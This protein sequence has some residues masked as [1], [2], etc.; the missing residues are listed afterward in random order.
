MGNEKSSGREGISAEQAEELKMK[1]KRKRE[2]E[3]LTALIHLSRIC[4]AESIYMKL[5]FYRK[6]CLE[7][8]EGN[9]RQLERC[10]RMKMK[11][12]HVPSPCLCCVIS[13]SC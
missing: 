12:R 3:V 2:R 11:S 10:W 9:W 4:L 13:F 1:E 7:K 5:F 8:N 6:T